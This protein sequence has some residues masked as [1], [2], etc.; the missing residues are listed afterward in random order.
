[1]RASA[2]YLCHAKRAFE[3]RP[4]RKTWRSSLD[5]F[6]PT[7]K[8]VEV[9]RGSRVGRRDW[10]A[11]HDAEHPPEGR[12]VRPPSEGIDNRDRGHAVGPRRC[13]RNFGWAH[14]VVDDECHLTQ[15]ELVDYCSDRIRRGLESYLARLD[16][17]AQPT[18][19][20]SMT[21]HRKSDESRRTRSRQMKPQAPTW[22]ISRTGPSPASV[23]T[24][25]PSAVTRER[26]S[27]GQA[28]W[29]SQS[30]RE[31]GSRP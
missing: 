30:G 9:A 25:F 16:S 13:G 21:M 17:N 11:A 26:I 7:P 18:A 27:Q 5:Q 6:R 23:T 3:S 12:A 24:T 14:E 1:M 2:K 19:G 10:P 15:V 31:R 28:L 29:G 20:A 4:A 22:S 8:R